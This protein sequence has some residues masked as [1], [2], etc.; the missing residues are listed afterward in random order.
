MKFIFKLTA[1][2]LLLAALSN[3]LIAEEEYYTW[4]DENGITNYAEK[5][6]QGYN[7][8]FVTPSSRF[9]YSTRNLN[10]EPER[11]SDNAPAATAA[12][13]GASETTAA[14]TDV[15]ADVAAEARRLREEQA[16]ARAENCQIGKE[17][18]VQLEAYS[19]IRVRGDDGKE[20][21]LT[22]AEKRSRRAEAEQIIR[23]N[24]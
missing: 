9:G 10:R 1:P 13:P 18:L 22:D 21:Y 23:D 15:A 14:P 3:P 6:P 2:A 20:R 7:A 24:C 12:P 17:R 19:R 4:V 5:E 16:A 11:A 8:T